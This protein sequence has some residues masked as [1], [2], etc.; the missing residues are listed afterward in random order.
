MIILD[1]TITVH[2]Q[3]E[4]LMDFFA[5][6]DKNYQA[7]SKD[8]IQVT[9]LQGHPLQE[10]SIFKNEEYFQGKP[11]QAKYIVKQ[12]IPNKRIEYKALFPQSLIGGR[13]VNQIEATNDGFV[14]TEIIYLGFNTPL[15]G[16]LID[17]LIRFLFVLLNGS[18]SDLKAHQTEGMKTVKHILEEKVQRR[19]QSPVAANVR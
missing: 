7:I 18:V 19:E 4:D 14:W 1:E 3:P 10:G 16:K 2:V 13:L 17:G 5:H 9:C 12:V 11:V 6:I 15:L 8:H